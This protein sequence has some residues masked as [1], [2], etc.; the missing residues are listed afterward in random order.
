MYPPLSAGGGVPVSV[1]DF[2]FN[3]DYISDDS[4]ADSNDI[5]LIL[6]EVIA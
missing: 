6:S 1:G 4:N 5:K 3:T 2:Y